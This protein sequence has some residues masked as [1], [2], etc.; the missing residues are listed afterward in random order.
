MLCILQKANV[1]NS[2][3]IYANDKEKKEVIIEI[4][5]KVGLKHGT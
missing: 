1:L 3:L 4:S 5:I 2:I